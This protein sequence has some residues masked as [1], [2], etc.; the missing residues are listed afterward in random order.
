[1]EL[2]LPSLFI[3]ILAA[4]IVFLVLPRFSPFAVISL[5]VVFLALAVYSH[6]K[7]YS[8]EYKNLMFLDT[9]QNNWMFLIAIIVLGFVFAFSNLFKG[10]KV[11][12]PKI[13]FVDDTTKGSSFKD[14]M[15]MPF[16]K[17]RDLERQV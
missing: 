8:N 10:F 2:F 9:L 17:I 1:M 16:D 4:L 15:S 6:F 14:L 12:I 3:L 7:V 13:I 11:K 5:C